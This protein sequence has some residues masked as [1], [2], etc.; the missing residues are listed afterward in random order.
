[1]LMLKDHIRRAVDLHG[2][3]GKLA[4]EVG[5]SQQYIS[6]LLRGDGQISAEL[7]IAF[8]RATGAVVTRQDL[9]PDIFEFAST[10][11]AAE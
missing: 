11:E 9:R 7:A 1:M 5:C 2:S 8:E 6:L 4:D 3:Q 10:P